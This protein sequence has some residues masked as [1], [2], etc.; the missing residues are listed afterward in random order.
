M[1]DSVTFD[2]ALDQQRLQRAFSASDDVGAV[3]RTHY[4]LDRCLSHVLAKYFRSPKKLGATRVSPK[5]DRL[6]ALGFQG[7]RIDLAR[8]IDEVRNDFAHR[9]VEELRTS[10]LEKLEVPTRL[11]MAGKV[12]IEDYNLR[13]WQENYHYGD[14]LRRQKFVVLGAMS[15]AVLAALPHEYGMLF[16]KNFNPLKA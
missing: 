12:S 11:L 15:I 5:L 6:E 4:E 8:A 7:P 2:F 1:T 9:D 10:D 16:G 14:L 3:I 13:L